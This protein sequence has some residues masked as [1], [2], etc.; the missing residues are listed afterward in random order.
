MKLRLFL[1]ATTRQHHEIDQVNIAS[2]G[3]I[4]YGERFG[5]EPEQSFDFEFNNVI[6]TLP[7][8]A[9]IATGAVADN[10]TTF[11]F[12]INGQDIGGTT[13]TG[14]VAPNGTR[15]N[16]NAARRVVAFRNN[17]SFNSDQL[18]FLNRNC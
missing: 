15:D 10:T 3:R 2:I 17:L 8:R 14:L 12:S 1:K 7:A 18:S 13:L 6:S 5:F 11:S 16:I 9:R 4:W